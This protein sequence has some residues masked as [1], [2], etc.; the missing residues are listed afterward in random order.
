[1]KKL[2]S[3]F[4]ILYISYNNFVVCYMSKEADYDAV[5]YVHPRVQYYVIYC[6]VFKLNTDMLYCPPVGCMLCSIKLNVIQQNIDM[7][8]YEWKSK[9]KG[10]TMHCFTQYFHKRINVLH[11]NYSIIHVTL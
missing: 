6:F 9:C 10:S 2:Y 11:R 5:L 7:N 3:T 4:H 8:S 1:M